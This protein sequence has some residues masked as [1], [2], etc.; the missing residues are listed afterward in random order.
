[1]TGPEDHEISAEEFKDSLSNYAPATHHDPL[2]KA[3]FEQAV[4][5]V[6]SQPCTVVAPEMPVHQAV[7]RLVNLEVA[8][9]VVVDERRLVGVFTKRDVLDKVALRYDEVKDCPVGQMMTPKPAFVYDSD[10]VGAALCVMASG[11]YRHVP[12]LDSS[13]RVVGVVGPIRVTT[14][15]QEYL[16]H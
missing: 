5:A 1:M 9:L 6:E 4:S 12:V 16:E 15:L 2:E 8:C 13:D 3:L 10:P 7:Q 11:G 14:F